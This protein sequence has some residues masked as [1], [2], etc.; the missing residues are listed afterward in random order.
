[1]V[2]TTVATAEGTQAPAGASPATERAENAA[3]AEQVQPGQADSQAPKPAAQQPTRTPDLTNPRATMREFLV[4]GQDALGDHPERIEDAVAC[5]DTSELAGEEAAEHARQLARRLH[6]IIDKRGVKLDDIPEQTDQDEF[7]FYQIELPEGEAPTSQTPA[8]RLERDGE[9]GRWLFTAATLGSIPV[10]EEEIAKKVKPAKPAET[11]VSAA[12]RSP[13]ATLTTF[14]EA[15]NA[16]PQDIAAAV[17]CLDRTGQAPEAWKVLGPDL[18]HKLKIVMDKIKLAVL[19]EIPDTPDGEPYVWET[20]TSGNIVI[21]R[22]E[23]QGDLQGEWRFTPQTLKTL[24]ALYLEYEDKSIVAE[25]Q[26]AGVRERLTFAL[27]LRKQMPPGFRAAFWHLEAWQW[28][29][30][31]ALLPLGWFIQLIAAALATLLLRKWFKRRGMGVGL[32]VQRRALRSS[33]AI[34]TVLFWFYAIHHLLLPPEALSVLLP[35]TRLALVVTAVWVGY[36][37][38]DVLGG[39]IAADKEVRLTRFDDVLIPLLRTIL[40][41]IVVL[42]VILAVLTW[43]GHPP[44]TVLGALGIG[45]LAV[46]FAAKDTLGNFFGS[47]TVLFDRPFGIGD[48]IV[49]GDVEGT[50]ERVGFRS[51]RVRT[52][53]NSMVT[54][55]NSY[56]VNTQVDNYGARRYRRARI[57]LS[58]TYNTPPDKIDAFCEGIREL[59]RLH[60]YTRKDYYHVYFNKFAASSLDILLYTFFE[61]P[62]WGT[63]LRERHR[64]FV[65]IVR[66]AKKLGVE[67]AFPTQT[68]WLERTREAAEEAQRGP[69]PPGVIE[70][71]DMG[72]GE[73]GRVFK[74]AYGDYPHERAP[75]VI[76]ST[77]RSQQHRQDDA[78]GGGG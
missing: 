50:V 32:D 28:L 36:R 66:L 31:L 42:L 29:A 61:V 35:I 13:R 71:D 52:F 65:D 37:F 76:H 47:I 54:L 11:K 44:K 51:T 77:P 49:V 63:E 9:T 21:G 27:W 2:A 15:M 17:Q 48:W 74:E 60:P 25:L 67:F 43:W 24:D 78:P 23:E 40:R 19:S 30:L 22:I 70:A 18:A 39:H 64:L 26:E 53:Y 73:A 55:P 5:L 75:V 20:R 10:L 38:V 58:I 62:D 57:M 16:D 46:A 14:L 6:R 12:R 1:M 34:V 69:V 41:L 8:I 68:V 4:A 59:I 33:G 3:T 56:I 7:V 45:G 72:I